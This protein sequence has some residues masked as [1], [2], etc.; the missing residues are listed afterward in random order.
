MKYTKAQVEQLHST[1]QKINADIVKGEGVDTEIQ[2]RMADELS[3]ATKRAVFCAFMQYQF[4]IDKDVTQRLQ[5]CINK[6]ATQRYHFKVKEGE[7]LTK[8]L[9]IRT[10]DKG[11]L[12]RNIAT[13]AQVAQKGVYHSFTY[14]KPKA[15]KL[16]Q[17]QKLQAIIKEFSITEVQFKANADK[18]TFHV[19]A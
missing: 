10:A 15:K 6:P 18:L 19:I 1:Y 8:V 5:N 9:S 7:P 3:N 2:K 11:L 13:K 4:G 16:T 12:A 17:L 14:A